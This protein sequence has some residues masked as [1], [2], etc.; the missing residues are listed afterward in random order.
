MSGTDISCLADLQQLIHMHS[1]QG[2]LHVVASS[3]LAIRSMGRNHEARTCLTRLRCAK[4]FN[5]TR[6]KHS[7]IGI[8]STRAPYED[9]HRQRSQ[10]CQKALGMYPAAVQCCPKLNAALQA[11]PQKAEKSSSGYVPDHV[12]PIA[13]FAA[14]GLGN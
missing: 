1:S 12:G 9:H 3:E 10:M 5:P 6:L 7:P 14:C 13:W 2:W 8:G 11:S 4:A